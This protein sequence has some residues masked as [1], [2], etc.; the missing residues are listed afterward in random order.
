MAWSIVKILTV[1]LL[2]LFT[3]FISSQS[4][5]TKFTIND[6]HLIETH[7]PDNH[8]YI[9]D[10]RKN[11]NSKKFFQL[12]CTSGQD[13]LDLNLTFTGINSITKKVKKIINL[14]SNYKF[15]F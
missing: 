9:V 12:L 15:K 8:V 5:E 3:Q 2:L 1:C 11:D 7:D 4:L 14:Q 6:K 13:S 10:F